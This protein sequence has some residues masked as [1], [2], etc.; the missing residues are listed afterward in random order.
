[1]KAFEGSK[2]EAGRILYGIGISSNVDDTHTIESE[3]RLIKEALVNWENSRGPSCNE[4]ALVFVADESRHA[5]ITKYAQFACSRDTRM[6]PLLA[7]CQVKMF[8]LN[9]AG[10]PCKEFA[11]GRKG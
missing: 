3:F 4:V 8:L 9:S 2:Q 5:G 6:A 11:F 7:R 1:M 10:Q